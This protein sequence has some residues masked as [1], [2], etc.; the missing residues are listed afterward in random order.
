MKKELKHF[1]ITGAD[2]LRSRNHALLADEMGLGKTVQA[3]AA[4]EKLN[5][6][7]IL[8]ICP[9][10][11]RTNWK[12]EI[13][14]CLGAE[15]LPR[16]SIISYNGAVSGILGGEWGWDAVILDE[17][18][19]LKTPDSQRTQAIFGNGKGLARGSERHI[20]GLTGTPVLNRPRE[21]YPILKTLHPEG[22][23]GYD[24]WGKF[25]QRYCGAFFDG[26]GI[27]TRGASNI[28]E[29][30]KGLSG[31]MLR[32]TKA[33]VMPELPPRIISHPAIELTAAEDRPIFEAE[34]AVQDREAYLSPTHEDYAQLGDL[35][36]LLRVTGVAKVR[37]VA[38]F[39]DDILETEDKVVIFC[40]HR[41]VITGLEN[42]L[43]H[44]LPVVYHGGM[45]D[46]KKK[47][48]V[49]EFV[50]HK[51][52]GV[53][54][55]QIQAAGTGINGLQKVCSNVV[56]AELSWVPGEM[57]QAIDRCHRIGQQSSAVNV[58][59]PHVPGT[60]ESAILQVQ[61]RK[62][63]VIEKLMGDGEKADVLEGLI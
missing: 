59:M 7:K 8:V 57:A 41:D 62:K 49:E 26:R 36:H 55:G 30:A 44:Y 11:V 34:A 17:V 37:A 16:F 27:N 4:V 46:E 40:R 33:D 38:D 54:I 14:E 1:Q 61:L 53:F 21:L 48:A 58:Y 52:C 10:S 5:L 23:A 20:W 25:T 60:L 2:F 28:A 47:R 45:N 56:F 15:F 29:L 24:T 43:G 39:V 22:I 31:F 13:E 51:D 9:A 19:F 32:R 35:S 3:L 18:H 63:A 12:Q 6:K 50:N 42:A